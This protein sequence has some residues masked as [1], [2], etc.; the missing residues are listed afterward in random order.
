[1]LFRTVLL[2]ASALSLAACQSVQIQSDIDFLSQAEPA[3][4][5]PAEPAAF[6][7]PGADWRAQGQAEVL[8][9]LNRPV[10]E[11]RARNVIVFIAD[12]MNPA[13]ITATRI[14]DG[15]NRGETGEENYLPFERW[16][17]TAMIKTYA[18]NAQVPDSAATASAI[19]TGVKTHMGA[20][21][22]YARDQFEPCQGGPVP[23]TLLEMAEARGLSTGVVSSA[24]LTHATP[25]SAY[26]HVSY[27][28]WESDT[29]L[30]QDARDAGCVDIA[31]QLLGTRE[32][33]LYGDGLDLALG[34][35]RAA[36][37][38]ED[39]GGQRQ[40][41]DLTTAWTDLGGVY[42]DSAA[43]FRALDASDDAPVLGLFTRSHLS[44]E[45][46]RDPAEEPSLAELTEFA[47]NRLSQDEEGFYLMVEAGRVDHAHHGTNAARALNDAL[48]FS[49]AVDRAQSM[50]DLDE[51]LILVTSDHGHVFTIAGYPRRGNPILGLVHPPA[52]NLTDAP[53]PPM[54]A[55]DGRPYTTLGYHNGAVLRPRSEDAE[56]L[57]QEQVLDP[58]FR[59]QAAIPMGS[60]THSGD[61]V[62]AFAVGPWAHL[63]DGT[64]EQHTLHHVITH[65]YGWSAT[66]DM[67]DA[68]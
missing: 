57:T 37:T 48:A 13:T 50:V 7:G 18:E 54:P 52:P 36:F 29:A 4:A 51:T 14:L 9:R 49:Q 59:Q 17:H 6:D 1:M 15:Q 46:D 25:A 3:Q 53:T 28:S 55:Q 26:A 24:R 47:I 34:G 11:G 40:D 8:A 33:P 31:A 23:Q 20:I 2:S 27:R 41:R 61:D 19:H 16:G 65:A 63:V 32:T 38:T 64:M 12:G 68:D 67:V 30:T 56:P 62:L 60:E 22:V 5:V 42:V 21:S 66:A 35:G 10:R 43:G 39:Q 58:D 44:Y 45:L